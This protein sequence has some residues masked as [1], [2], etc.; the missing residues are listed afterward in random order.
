MISDLPFFSIHVIDP[1]AETLDQVNVYTAVSTFTMA[2]FCKLNDAAID[3]FQRKAGIARLE[4]LIDILSEGLIQT[5][6]IR[7]MKIQRYFSKMATS[8]SNKNDEI[9]LIV[10]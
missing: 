5:E 1:A 4:N 10:F 3:R 7:L 8:P 9:V 6:Y 2:F